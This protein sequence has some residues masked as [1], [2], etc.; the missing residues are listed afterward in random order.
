MRIFIPV[1]VGHT[2]RVK[3]SVWAKNFNVLVQEIDYGLSSIGALN[4]TI[5]GAG[6]DNNSVGVV[7]TDFSYELIKLS[8]SV[9]SFNTF[10]A[11]ILS[12]QK[13][14]CNILEL[15]NSNTE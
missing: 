14:G 10:C 12:F 2:I 1:E 6:L 9:F 11:E 8:W 4:C 15:F 3:N 7:D 13:F 5:K